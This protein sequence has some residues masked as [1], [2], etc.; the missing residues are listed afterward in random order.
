VRIALDALRPDTEIGTP[1]EVMI[2]LAKRDD[3]LLAPTGAIL[4]H[5]GRQ[6]VQ[7]VGEGG[8]RRQVNVQTGIAT[9]AETEIVK[10]LSEGQ[11]VLGQ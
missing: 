6:Y 7:V 2:T 5:S 11:R 10:G 1:A 3:A 4:R 8:Q 9:S